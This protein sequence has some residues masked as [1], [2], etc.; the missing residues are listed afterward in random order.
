MK[1]KK[2][3]NILTL[4]ESDLK[5]IIKK[6]ITEQDA[7]EDA[8]NDVKGSNTDIEYNEAVEFCEEVENWWEGSD[9]HFNDPERDNDT[10]GT[11]YVDFFSK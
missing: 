9:S 8:L 6:V 2:N 5:K 11:N 3:G 4:S 10:T 7:L 1:I